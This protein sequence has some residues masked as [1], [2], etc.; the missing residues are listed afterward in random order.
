MF[1]ALIWLDNAILFMLESWRFSV[2]I[3]ILGYVDV[4]TCFL[5]SIILEVIFRSVSKL[6]VK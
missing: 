1:R 6:I 2:G 5:S 3:I 4:R